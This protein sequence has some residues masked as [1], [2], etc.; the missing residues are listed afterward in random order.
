MAIWF[1][2]VQLPPPPIR[3]VRACRGEPGGGGGKCRRDGGGQGRVCRRRAAVGE[4]SGAPP[5]KIH[6]QK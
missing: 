3:A 1:A 6:D 2:V 4:S 5:N